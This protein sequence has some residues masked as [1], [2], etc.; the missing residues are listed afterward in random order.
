MICHVNLVRGD[1]F[2]SFSVHVA[3]NSRNSFQKLTDNFTEFVGKVNFQMLPQN[4]IPKVSKCSPATSKHLHSSY[5]NEQLLLMLTGQLHRKWAITD[6]AG[7]YKIIAL[8]L[9][10]KTKA[11][12]GKVN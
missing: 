1:I 4:Q 2:Q 11:I 3:G 5:K 12:T 7:I 8:W 10:C 6:S 9:C